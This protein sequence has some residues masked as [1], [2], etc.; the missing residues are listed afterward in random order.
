MRAVGGVVVALLVSNQ[1]QGSREIQHRLRQGDPQEQAYLSSA[2]RKRKM[3]IQAGD[4][5]RCR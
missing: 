3:S 2:E 5:M 1:R 4:L